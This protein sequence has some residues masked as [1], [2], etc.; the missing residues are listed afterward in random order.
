MSNPLFFVVSV[1]CVREQV[2]TNHFRVPPSRSGGTQR[3]RP[4]RK[5]LRR[6][7]QSRAAVAASDRYLVAGSTRIVTFADSDASDRVERISLGASSLHRL[8]AFKVAGA[9][10]R[11]RD[12]NRTAV[13]VM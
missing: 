10:R 7:R 4:P 3:P 12:M 1:P 2:L 11:R 6:L 8:G 13:S 5:Q 9:P